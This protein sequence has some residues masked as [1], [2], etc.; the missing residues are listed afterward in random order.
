MNKAKILQIARSLYDWL[1][2]F[3]GFHCKSRLISFFIYCSLQHQGSGESVLR[4][5]LLIVGHYIKNSR[6]LS[7]REVTF[8]F[9]FGSKE[10]IERLVSAIEAFDRMIVYSHQGIQR[11]SRAENGFDVSIW[12]R[13]SSG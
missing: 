3:E 5:M 6:I 1:R 10:V 7:D 8:I 12:V 13:T 9:R 2:L 11:V 4:A